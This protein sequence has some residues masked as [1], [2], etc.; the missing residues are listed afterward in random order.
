MTFLSSI[1][2]LPKKI[3]YTLWE[4]KDGKK[5]E[6]CKLLSSSEKK[7]TLNSSTRVRKPRKRIG[8]EKDERAAVTA[9][10][11]SGEKCGA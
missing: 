1:T 3:V 7:K 2:H 11:I 10:V 6:T 8:R 9:N 5:W 4:D